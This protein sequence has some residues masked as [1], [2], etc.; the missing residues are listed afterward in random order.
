MGEITH[1]VNALWL[2]IGLA[3]TMPLPG[4]L[5]D[6]DAHADASRTLPT[7]PVDTSTPDRPGI[8]EWW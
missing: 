3:L 1:A 8:R 5:W 2:L 7:D 6:P 4:D